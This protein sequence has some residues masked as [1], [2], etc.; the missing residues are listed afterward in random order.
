MQPLD[1]PHPPLTTRDALVAA[2]TELIDKGGPEAVT[3]RAVAKTVG[4]SH[5][6]PYKHFSDR[7]TLLAAVASK[8]LHRLA[9]LLDH[10]EENDA[11]VAA[12]GKVIGRY[13]DWAFTHPHRFRLAFGSWTQHHAELGEA[14]ALAQ[15]ALIA[16]VQRAQPEADPQTILRRAILLHAALHGTIDLTLNGHLGSGVKTGLGASDL[17]SDLLALV[18]GQS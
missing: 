8:E 11:P 4:I 6:A 17:V 9:E 12:L 15:K 3:L 1:A 5:N 7:E 18:F 14:A 16:A 13:F 10:A 2:A